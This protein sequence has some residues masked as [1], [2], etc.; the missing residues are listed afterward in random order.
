MSQS[1][2]EHVK[3][4]LSN[5]GN[6]S[7]YPI[8]ELMDTMGWDVFENPQN[9]KLRQDYIEKLEGNFS[10]LYNTNKFHIHTSLYNSLKLLNIKSVHPP[11]LL[12]EQL[13]TRDKSGTM[14][15]FS[16]RFKN[17]LLTSPDG[18][19]KTLELYTDSGYLWKLNEDDLEKNK[20]HYHLSDSKLQNIRDQYL[21]YNHEEQCRGW[22]SDEVY[23]HVLDNELN[24]HDQINWLAKM[25]TDHFTQRFLESMISRL[26]TYAPDYLDWHVLIRKIHHL[27]KNVDHDTEVCKTINEIATLDVVRNNPE[28]RKYLAKKLLISEGYE[29]PEEILT[30]HDADHDLLSFKP[31]IA[32]KIQ[33]KIKSQILS[34]I[35]SNVSQKIYYHDHLQER[36]L[37]TNGRGI[38]NNEARLKQTLK[39]HILPLLSQNHA[40]DA[41]LESIIE[42]YRARNPD[43]QLSP[44][45][46]ALQAYQ[47]FSDYFKMIFFKDDLSLH[48]LM[49]F[50]QIIRTIGMQKYEEDIFRKSLKRGISELCKD[51]YNL[52]YGDKLYCIL[53][54]VAGK[55][56]DLQQTLVIR[57]G[58]ALGI[59]EDFFCEIVKNQEAQ[60]RLLSN[61]LLDR[62]NLTYY[63]VEKEAY[64][65]KNI[66]TKQC[67]QKKS[68]YNDFGE[69][70]RVPMLFRNHVETR[71]HRI[72]NKNFEYSGIQ[73]GDTHP[74]NISYTMIPDIAI[75]YASK[76]DEQGQDPC[77]SWVLIQNAGQAINTTE[78]MEN[79]EHRVAAQEFI[80]SEAMPN[81][82]LGAVKIEKIKELQGNKVQYK[83]VDGF[84]SEDLYEQITH[85][86]LD[87]LRGIEGKFKY[88]IEAAYL[89][90]DQSLGGTKIDAI[91]PQQLEF[92][93]RK[94]AEQNKAEITQYQT[95]FDAK[96]MPSIK[97]SGQNNFIY[98]INE[99]VKYH[100]QLR[101]K[102]LHLESDSTDYYAK[103][104]HVQQEEKQYIKEWQ[105]NRN[106]HYQYKN[107]GVEL[108]V[109]SK[110]E[111]TLTTLIA[112]EDYLSRI[113][114]SGAVSYLAN[115][116]LQTNKINYAIEKIYRDDPNLLSL[117]NLIEHSIHKKELN[118]EILNIVLKI[119]SAKNG[120]FIDSLDKDLQINSISSNQSFYRQV[121]DVF[122]DNLLCSLDFIDTSDVLVAMRKQNTS[123]WRL[124][125]NNKGDDHHLLD[126]KEAQ[127]ENS[128]QNP[129]EKFMHIYD[130]LMEE[131]SNGQLK[132]VRGYPITAG[133]AYDEYGNRL[134]AGTP[135]WN[136]VCTQYWPISG[137]DL[138]ELRK[139]PFITLLEVKAIP[140]AKT[141][142]SYV[143]KY[144]YPDLRDL[145]KESMSIYTNQLD[146]PLKNDIAALLEK[147]ITS[148]ANTIGLDGYNAPILIKDLS[149]KDFIQLIAGPREYAEL[150][151]EGLSMYAQDRAMLENALSTIPEYKKLLDDFGRL[152]TEFLKKILVELLND[153]KLTPFQRYKSLMSLHPLKDMNGRC[154]RMFYRKEANRPLYMFNWD[155]DIVMNEEQINHMYSNYQNMV[156][157]LKNESSRAKEQNDVPR[158]YDSPEFW[159]ATFSI[160]P[161]KYTQTERNSLSKLIQIELDKPDVRESIS[162]KAYYSYMNSIMNAVYHWPKFKILSNKDHEEN[163]ALHLACMYNIP[164]KQLLKNANHQGLALEKLINLHGQT[165]MHVAA[166][167]LN[168]DA[169]EK[170]AKFNPNLYD[171]KDKT[172]KTYFDYIMEHILSCTDKQFDDF[173]RHVV[174]TKT[175][176]IDYKYSDNQSVFDKLQ[177]AGQTKHCRK[178][179]NR[180]SMFSHIRGSNLEQNQFKSKLNE[181]DSNESN[182]DPDLL[183]K[184]N[185]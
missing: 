172:D 171:C 138:G 34:E 15:G 52:G 66:L 146:Q 140:D 112:A 162:Q 98:D 88:F 70:N 144:R 4:G 1:I 90:H 84:L 155:Q 151:N 41:V 54:N 13:L 175:N 14:L 106:W 97:K 32:R 30:L 149:N 62:V 28:V 33:D 139:N 99:L 178:L 125:Q 105:K 46:A 148:I 107:I 38:R 79:N 78:Y 2:A 51:F 158:Y 157:A 134:P 159:L 118:H 154:V 121:D 17:I 101:K 153:Q 48:K 95:L 96:H 166:M 127:Q 169:I 73:L 128:S 94:N 185:I 69:Y 180:I 100:S 45:H 81:K 115:T 184:L 174:T 130:I 10:L 87:K 150:C 177:L 119:A 92:E 109:Q 124:Y 49:I 131:Q 40:L 18:L 110:E 143:C 9:Q 173:T 114:L 147:D 57:N 12:F 137:N 65:N 161:E 21:T 83:I 8:I 64:L 43:Q 122:F 168:F 42:D 76:L 170:L 135:T 167:N 104:A 120:N 116:H 53:S 75:S 72:N 93:A 86:S 126:W 7:L 123:P 182:H 80:V 59:K 141:H 16:E 145:N 133:G 165:A 31:E 164:I 152:N 129:S 74:S 108:K 37:P 142:A 25:I 176:I 113:L 179:E 11:E 82:Q 63:D 181:L 102:T 58:H 132:G 77:Y 35:K 26:H 23:K 6:E 24:S 44:Y 39:T 20:A 61:L 3:E 163:T 55:S 89:Y 60:I 103:V 68:H 156:G 71:Q 5:L 136:S 111:L 29:K 183:N 67:I 50:S 160:N 27:I 85:D 19:K 22:I 56:I 91:S 117:K 36:Y 47:P